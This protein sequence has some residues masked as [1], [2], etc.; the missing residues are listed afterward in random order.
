MKPRFTILVVDD[1]ADALLIMR[2][3]LVRAGFAVRTAG[4]GREALVQFRAEPADMVMLDVDMPE[5]DGFEVCSTLRAEVGALLPIVM[6][7]GMDDLAS[8]EAA[9]EHGATDFV[10]K[11]V[12]WALMGHRVRYLFRGHQA[13]LDLRAS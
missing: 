11:P 6:V 13:M 10:S 9:Y 3:A 4:G 12:N 8:V 2:A 5:L 1:D 7:T